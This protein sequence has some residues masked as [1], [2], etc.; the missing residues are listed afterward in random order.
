M[1]KSEFKKGAILFNEGEPLH[2]ILFITKGTAKAEFMGRTLSFEQ[3]D[4]IGLSDLSV[5]THSRTYIAD[6]DI[7][8]FSYPYDNPRTLGKLLSENADV[9]NLL[10]GSMC[11]QLV[12]MLQY[13][14]LLRKEVDGANKLIAEVY[15]Q[16]EKLCNLY[17]FS[18]KKIP[19]ISEVAQEPDL[20]EDWLPSYYLEIKELI[21][22]VQKL[23]FAQPGISLG[24]LCR[25]AD[26]YLRLMQACNDYH[27]YLTEVSPNFLNSEGHDLFALISDLHLD[28]INI[29]GADAAVEPFVKL[30]TSLLPN[31]TGVDPA[32]YKERL[33]SYA[34]NLKAK[35]AAQE[36]TDAPES[37]VKQNLA[38]SLDVILAYSEGPEEEFNKFR[39]GVYEYRGLPDRGSS[40]EVAYR[41]RRELTELFYVVYHSVFM[42]SLKDPAIPTV[43][44]MFLNFGYV[45]AALAGYDNADYL[46]SI[47][48]SLKGNPEVG[49]YTIMEWLTAIYKGEKEPCRNDFDED[50]AA[51]VQ[52]LK[53][54]RKIDEKEEKRLLED[55]MGKLQ[56]ELENV[57]PIVNKVT[58]GRVT[59]FCPL[60]SDNNVQRGLDVSMITP[61][62]TEDIFDEIRAVDFTAYYREIVYTNPEAGVPREYI[63]VEIRPNIILTP[64]M[65][66]RGT[67]WQE[68]EGRKRNTPARIFLPIFLLGDLKNVLTRLTAEYR[69]EMCKR[70]Q[71]PRWTD[72][73]DPS[74]TADFFDYLQFYK[75]NR[76]LSTDVKA[77]VKTELVRAKNTYKSVFVSNYVDWV[78]YE[79]NGSPR[80][81][82]Y[83]RRIF[84]VYCPFALPI[85]EKLTLNPQY[86]ELLRRYDLK[87]Q[88]R[89][90]HLI[91]VTQKIGQGGFEVP[92][93][94]LD[95][96][97]YVQ[98]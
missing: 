63:N 73:T 83:A 79:A 70:I 43:I 47:A 76:E 13:R 44:K 21:P 91:R 57:F 50:Y 41:L 88:Q 98:S 93:E 95:E 36:I 90:Q 65:G 30:L 96:L 67:M 82:K 75:S 85:R 80:L 81:N 22:G 78:A 87:Q 89:V 4:A 39:R 64:L 6:S 12:E 60:F 56:F 74:L 38:D 55:T 77:A 3:G 86:A 68:I 72:I 16:Y 84:S 8:A 2:Q 42:K 34:E 20:I 46:Y 18:A 7:T 49:V 51:H 28:S 40:N 45:D 58:F 9:A 61:K 94:L 14:A 71:G 27:K 5:G 11:R 97:E 52:G 54:Q 48:D 26:D 59:T 17:A 19:D 33:I 23:F 15:P 92:Q 35:R 53:A 62:Q 31:M 10:V 32:V 66:T 37:G 29:R 1:L 24:F 69:W 25:G